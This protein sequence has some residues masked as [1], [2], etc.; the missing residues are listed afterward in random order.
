MSEP[1]ET[2]RKLPAGVKAATER[3]FTWLYDTPQPADALVM[4][5][6][7]DLTFGN[8]DLTVGIRPGATAPTLVLFVASP[9]QSLNR[10]QWAEWQTLVG[11]LA[12]KH[13][14]GIRRT[15]NGP[16]THT[17]AMVLD[18]PAHPTLVAAVQ[19]YQAGCPR[20]RGA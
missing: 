16:P 6:G 14:T 20:H 7:R 2:V 10:A 11:K 3:A 9:G 12:K 18:A 15:F 8:T 5:A 13:K 19:R 1:K 17:G 4:P